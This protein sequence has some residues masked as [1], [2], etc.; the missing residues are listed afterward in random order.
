M[1]QTLLSFEINVF[2]RFLCCLNMKVYSKKHNEP[3]LNTKTAERLRNN[4]PKGEDIILV[5]QDVLMPNAG[6]G[7]IFIFMHDGMWCQIKTA[8][9]VFAQALFVVSVIYVR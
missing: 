2:Q 6:N 9:Y 1:Q 3:E 7:S 8:E 5:E 4:M